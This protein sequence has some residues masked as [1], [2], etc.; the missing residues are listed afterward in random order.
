[1]RWG[2]GNGTVDTNTSAYTGGQIAG[3]IE[4]LLPFALES[5]ATY[6]AA[7]AARGTPSISN[8]NSFF[9]IGT[10]AM[11]CK[12]GPAHFQGEHSAH[13]PALSQEAIKDRDAS[14]GAPERELSIVNA[15]PWCRCL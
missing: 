3:T 10:R 2:I 9:Q 11:G 6:S 8:A 7:Q 12:Q 4:G 13:T 1:M 15:R 14:D 5:A